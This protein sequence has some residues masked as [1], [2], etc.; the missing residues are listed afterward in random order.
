MPEQYM[1][2]L[3]VHPSVCHTLVLYRNSRTDPGH[4]IS[5]AYYWP[6]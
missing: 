1:L 2:W 5:E 4:Q 3:C 6:I